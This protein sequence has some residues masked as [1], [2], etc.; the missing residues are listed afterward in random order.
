[1]RKINSFYFETQTQ[2]T[3]FYKIIYRHFKIVKESITQK[4]E[5]N[6]TIQSVELY[7]E[8]RSRN[9]METLSLN[10]V[11]WQWTTI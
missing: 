10:N 7:A 8:E 2:N 3:S 1:M 6:D 9:L 4:D 5:S 11:N